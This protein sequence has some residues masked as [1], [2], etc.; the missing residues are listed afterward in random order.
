M[1]SSQAILDDLKKYYKDEA[2]P[3]RCEIW[4]NAPNCNN[5]YIYRL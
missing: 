4:K 2:Y 5:R 1:A 3:E